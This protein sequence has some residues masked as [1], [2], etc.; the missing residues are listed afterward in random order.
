MSHVRQ[1]IL[2]SVA[3]AL[4]D[5]GG[6]HKSRFYPI[7]SDEL[8]VYLIYAGDEEVEGE[9][10]ALERRFQV[11]V[12][13]VADG[14]WTDETLHQCLASV[15]TRLTSTLSSLVSSFVLATI[16]VGTSVEGA[17]PIARMR[18]TYEAMYRTSYTDPETSI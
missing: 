6:V 11:I 7:G 15:E 17:K 4:A 9:F 1:Q 10:T 13:I 3:S 5:L 8:P 12:E 16:T 18:I 2:D 14:Q